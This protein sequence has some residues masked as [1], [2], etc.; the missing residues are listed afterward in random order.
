M[1]LQLVLLGS[2]DEEKTIR[3]IRGIVA[4]DRTEKGGRHDTQ[5]SR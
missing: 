3:E 4:R 2:K 1:V 5:L